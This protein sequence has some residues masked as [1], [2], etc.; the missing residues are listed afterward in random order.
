MPWERQYMPLLRSLVV[1]MARAAINMAL[2]TELVVCAATA[3]D[4]AVG[5]PICAAPTEL[6]GRYGTRGYKHGA[7]NGAFCMRCHRSLQKI[8]IRC[9]AS[10]FRSFLYALPH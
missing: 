3:A 8:H 2:L 5:R 10:S 7:P 4:N 1:I 6:G 9:R